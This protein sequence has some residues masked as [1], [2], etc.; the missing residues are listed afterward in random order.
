MKSAELQRLRFYNLIR[1]VPSSTECVALTPIPVAAQEPDL[2]IETQVRIGL[3]ALI[4]VLLI[5]N[6]GVN[7]FWRG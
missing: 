6:V 3:G 1:R 4:T 2:S 7:I 5:V